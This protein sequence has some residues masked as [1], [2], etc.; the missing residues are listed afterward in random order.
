MRTRKEAFL[1]FQVGRVFSML[2]IEA[3]GGQAAFDENDDAYTEVRYG[4][5]AHSNIRRFIIVEERREFVYA[6]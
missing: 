4:Q 1:F 6:W 3:A 2:H 5:L